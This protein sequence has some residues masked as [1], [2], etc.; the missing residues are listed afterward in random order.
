MRIIFDPTSA[1]RCMRFKENLPD[2][3][4]RDHIVECHD[5]NAGWVSG[6]YFFRGRFFQVY[7][8]KDLTKVGAH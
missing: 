8:A 2:G 3:K 1:I 7:V 6:D 5:I 4:V